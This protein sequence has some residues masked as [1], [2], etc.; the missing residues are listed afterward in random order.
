MCY[1][2]VASTDATSTEVVERNQVLYG[3]TEGARSRPRVLL[4]LAAVMLDV[5]RTSTRVL[6]EILN[7]PASVI[8]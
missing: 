6:K 2:M 1:A 8:N 3:S 5:H 4:P 7:I